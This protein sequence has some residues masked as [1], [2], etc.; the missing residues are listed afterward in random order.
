[1]VPAPR[2]V[3]TPLAYDVLP[4]ASGAPTSQLLQPDGN[5]PEPALW[6]TLT[7]SKVEVFSVPGATLQTTNPAVTT[8]APNVVA[9]IVIQVLPSLE[10]AASTH[11]SV[12]VSRSH[13]GGVGL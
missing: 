7:E 12:R 8:G 10:T 6:N 5:P 2:T 4:W 1:M 3:K 13:T 11:A 9:P